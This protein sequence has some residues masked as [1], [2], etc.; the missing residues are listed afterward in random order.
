MM[1]NAAIRTDHEKQFNTG[2]QPILTARELK[3]ADLFRHAQPWRFGKAC[4]GRK[5]RVVRE[6]LRR[7]A[8]CLARFDRSGNCREIFPAISTILAKLNAAEL[9][10]PEDRRFKWSRRTVLAYLVRLE[11][12]GIATAG[13]LSHCHGTRRRELHPDRLLSVPCESCTPTPRESCTRIKSLKF[14]ESRKKKQQHKGAA[15]AA[16]VHL[17][18]WKA[19]GL[20][21]PVGNLKIRAAWQAHYAQRN[22]QPLSH[23]L[24]QLLDELQNTGKPILKPFAQAIARL[25]AQEQPKP[26]Y[27]TGPRRPAVI[28]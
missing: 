24:G 22:G 16:F 14:H 1:S 9:N 8:R 28:L 10:Y 27:A 11:E 4:D 3:A 13:G 18:P 6:R 19:I 12:R 26:V 15:A 20:D 23:I 21:R 25:R 2:L 17:E 7:L 5:F